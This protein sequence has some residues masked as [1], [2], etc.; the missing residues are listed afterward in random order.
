MT[1]ELCDSFVVSPEYDY[2]TKFITSA[3]R[4][5]KFQLAQIE[6]FFCSIRPEFIQKSRQ[7]FGE[8]L[9]ALDA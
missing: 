8:G 3:V 9:R 6:L 1:C 5:G 7:H 2:G 4:T